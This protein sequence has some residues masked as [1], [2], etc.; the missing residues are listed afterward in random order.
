MVPKT[1]LDEIEDHAHYGASCLLE[2]IPLRYPVIKRFFS[3]LISLCGWIMELFNP[4]PLGSMTVVQ[5]S[6]RI[7][8]FTGA[9][10][11]ASILFAMA[12]AVG[13]YIM[14]R[15]RELRDTPEFYH[16][17][18]IVLVGIVVNAGCVFVL[19]QLKKTDT[20]LVPPAEKK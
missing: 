5:K 19:L 16:G 10:V 14:E 4:P 17:L 12:G 18:M 13:L 15:G 6:G 11:I 7:L 2:Q 20:R 3:P 8:L 1:H 9:L